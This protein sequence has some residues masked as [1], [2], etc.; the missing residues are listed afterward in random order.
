[1]R[2]LGLAVAAVL[3]SASVAFAQSNNVKFSKEPFAVNAEKLSAYLDLTPG[4]YNEVAEINEY[5]MD[6]Q[7]ESLRASAKLQAK[8]MHQAVYGNL[9]LMKKALTPD[10]YRKYLVLLNITN[11][12]N[13][14]MGMNAMPDVYLADNK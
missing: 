10:Q 13:R 12:N 1:M 11:N 9:K 2:T 6:K 5:F 4:Q 8:K 3:M 7:S 14:L